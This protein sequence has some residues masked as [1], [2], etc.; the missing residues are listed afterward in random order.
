MTNENV[1]ENGDEKMMHLKQALATK[2]IDAAA[3]GSKKQAMHLLS[4]IATRIE[5]NNLQDPWKQWLIDALREIGAGADPR[6]VLMTSGRKGKNPERESKFRLRDRSIRSYMHRLKSA[7][8][9]LSKE[10]ACH[11]VIEVLGLTASSEELSLAGVKQICDPKNLT[12]EELLSL[13]ANISSHHAIAK[14]YDK[15]ADE[16]KAAYEKPL[17]VDGIEYDRT[18]DTRPLF[19]KGK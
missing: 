9:D 5:E 17:I 11:E 7:N 10:D 4:T 6:K 14:I 3:A 15:I 12:D 16:E 18:Y 2:I 19:S 8:P 1:K 13:F